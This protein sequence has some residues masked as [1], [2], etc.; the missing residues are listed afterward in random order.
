MHVIQMEIRDEHIKEAENLLLGGKTFDTKERLSFIKSLDT[1]DL[2]A[3]PGSGK[4]TA[5]QAKL[6]CL[7]QNLPIEDGSGILVLSHTNAAVEEIENNLKGVCPQLFTYPNF[8]GTIQSFVDTF[9]AFPFFVHKNHF[10]P[11]LIEYEEYNKKVEY[12]LKYQRGSVAYFKNKNPDLF[13]QCF[14]RLSPNKE[15][16][17]EYGGKE[18]EDIFTNIPK[19][20]IEEGKRDSN[21]R[22]ILEF[23]KSMKSDI[24]K[25]GYLNFSDSY[26]Y[27]DKYISDYPHI[28]QLIR[29]RFKYIFIDETQDLE[30][31]QIDLIDKLFY[32][33]GITI[34]QRVGDINQSIYNSSKTV[35]IDIDWKTRNEFYLTGSNRLTNEI[36]NVVN[37]FTL[38]RQEDDEG[39]PKFKVEGLRISDK[40]IKPHLLIFDND[41]RSQLEDKFKELITSFELED[42]DEGKKYGFHIIGWNANWEDE[43]KDQS[44]LRLEDIFPNYK[45]ETKSSKSYFNTLSEYIQYFNTNTKTLGNAKNAILDFLLQVLY[46]ENKTYSRTIRGVSREVRYNQPELL[47]R[48]R[49]DD[50]NYENFKLK[51]F[52]WSFSLMMRHDFEQVYTDIKTFVEGEFKEWFGLTINTE[53]KVLLEDDFKPLVILPISENNIKN[54]F[55]IEISTVHAVKGK[56]HCATMYVETAYQRPIY[57]TNKVIKLTS[58]PFLNEKHKCKG[59]YDTQAMRMMYVGFS[60]PTHLL[61]FAVMK[62][63]LTDDQ[64]KKMQDI[65]WEKIDLTQN[66]ISTP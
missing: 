41:S 61:C 26:F 40:S 11:R 21:I 65:G 55:P 29:S 9:L 50:L 53:T 18:N 15:I 20:W 34:I 44:K 4:T 27:A 60:R 10:R 32:D 14:L 23:I 39:N 13:K 62:N 8:V 51:L 57:E 1:I 35:K 25:E 59:V 47:K 17:V 24:F 45:K 5:L 48:L 28:I 2:L 7:A 54:D 38:D 31:H 66:I 6:Y 56:T 12:K 43:K 52:S 33:N 42:T 3:V 19:K 16:I 37:N 63:N 49:E 64:L 30:K 46:L 36:A 22:E 58:N